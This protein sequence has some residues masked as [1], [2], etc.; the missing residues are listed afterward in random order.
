MI[1][2]DL[3]L[4][5]TSIN[6]PWGLYSSIS[7]RQFY[8]S[9][10]Y[11][12]YTNK[13]SEYDKIKMNEVNFEIIKNNKLPSSYLNDSRFKEFYILT[14]RSNPS[15]INADIIFQTEDFKLLKFK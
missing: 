9:S 12:D 7:E 4:S 6:P 15:N 1:F 8:L 11:S 5:E 14:H 2:S 10:F 3:N 13:F